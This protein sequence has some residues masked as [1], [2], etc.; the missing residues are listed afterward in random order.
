MRWLLVNDSEVG[1]Q[2]LR[3][4][5][6]SR[7]IWKDSQSFSRGGLAVSVSSSVPPM[8]LLS[9]ASCRTRLSIKR[10]NA[11]T[12]DAQDGVRFDCAGKKYLVS[13]VRTKKRESSDRR[14]F[15]L[16]PER[17]SVRRQSCAWNRRS[18]RWPSC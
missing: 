12:T 9:D 3:T 2:S 6:E 8:V 11:I 1:Q 4:S 15:L 14:S 16:I 5:S 17:A 10:R 18:P 13:I 7:A